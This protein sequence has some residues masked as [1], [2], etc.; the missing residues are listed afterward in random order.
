MQ[1][2]FSWKDNS[3]KIN[4][5]PR[6]LYSI[7]QEIIQSRVSLKWPSYSEKKRKYR[8]LFLLKKQHRKH[9]QLL[10]FTEIRQRAARK[11]M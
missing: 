4:E 11:V 1:K 6:I 9:Y 7:V 5:Y 2:N 3:T 10:S 8:K